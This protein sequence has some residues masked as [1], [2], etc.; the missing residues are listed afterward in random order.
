MSLLINL[1]LNSLWTL[2]SWVLLVLHFIA[3]ISIWWFWGTLIFWFLML[4]IMTISLIAVGKTGEISVRPRKNANP[5]SSD[6]YKP[7]E[8]K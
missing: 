7:P 8:N 3:K 1:G 5:Y 6:G 4:V 2:P